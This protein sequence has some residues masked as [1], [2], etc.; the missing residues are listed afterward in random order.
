MKRIY[1]FI[2]AH[3]RLVV[4]A[5]LAVIAAEAGFICWQH[6]LQQEILSRIT[7][8]AGVA[9]F[10]VVSATPGESSFF[11]RRDRLH[12]VLASSIY[13]CDPAAAPLSLEFDVVANFGPFG[14]TGDV[15][16]LNSTADTAKLLKELAG[17]H[18]RLSIRFRWALFARELQVT[19][20]A[21]PFDMQLDAD[22]PGIGPTSWRGAA[23]RPVVLRAA[24]PRAGEMRARVEAPDFV[25]TFT[26]P[27]ANIMR[28]TLDE[29]E[30]T[31]RA[32]VRGVKDDEDP[33]RFGTGPD[34]FLETARLDAKR[35]S[36]EAGDWRGALSVDLRR[37]VS[38]MRQ[39]PA[40]R[41]S[42]LEGAYEVHAERLTAA[43]KS[44][45]SQYDRLVE[46]RDFALRLRASNV[47]TELFTSGL[48]DTEL[49]D[50][51]KGAGAMHFALDDLSFSADRGGR[52]SFA[53]ELDVG[54]AELREGAKPAV[55]W[56]LA[57]EMP[58]NVVDLADVIIHGARADL[59][60][61]SLADLMERRAGE[62]ANTSVYTVRM[63]G[64]NDDLF[65]LRPAA[66]SP[67]AAPAGADGVSAAEEGVLQ[68][69][70]AAPAAAPSIPQAVG[71]ADAPGES[72]AP[73]TPAAEPQ[74]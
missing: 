28:L 40:V 74:P 39:T 16:P 43:V 67:A 26:D 22:L 59:R 21:A 73:D 38:E 25:L 5:A 57:A 7:S 61:L 58:Q 50:L 30:L 45:H 32:R 69:P 62:S 52:T 33:D 29:G 18:P 56:R 34:W 20:T 8:P 37:P 19:A 6:S 3:S 17:T 41:A 10:V 66:K 13:S 44:V 51:I 48:D 47:P 35:L 54:G 23:K 49:T 70:A 60:S 14:L 15:Y 55:S 36:V 9:E 11:E 12:V 71:A 27:A 46:G 1:G 42:R 2:L 31:T 72:A 53:A 64:D 65:I 68:Q 24:M 4:G 63:A